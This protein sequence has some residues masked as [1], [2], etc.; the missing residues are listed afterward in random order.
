MFC[1]LIAFF[2]Q[3]WNAKSSFSVRFVLCVCLRCLGFRASYLHFTCTRATFHQSFWSFKR[4][5]SPCQRSM[6]VKKCNTLHLVELR[7]AFGSD[8][9]HR[10]TAIYHTHVPGTAA[11]E[12]H[13]KR[14][15]EDVFFS[16][17]RFYN[18]TSCHV[19]NGFKLLAPISKLL[20]DHVVFWWHYNKCIRFLKVLWMAF[21]VWILIKICS[22]CS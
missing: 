9:R 12:K 20:G 14:W 22:A 3:F 1:F 5:H 7:K 11:T 17:C 10:Q 6:A 4:Y 16:P 2:R 13:L 15:L 21:C 19:L 18:G 8:E